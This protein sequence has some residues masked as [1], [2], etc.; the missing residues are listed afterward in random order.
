MTSETIAGTTS[1]RARAATA[2]AMA[3][4]RPGS[5]RGTIAEARPAAPPSGADTRVRMRAAAAGS[6]AGGRTGPGRAWGPAAGRRHTART[7]AVPG[8]ARVGRGG[9]PAC[10]SRTSRRSRPTA[11]TVGGSAGRGPRLG[12]ALP[13][14]ER[15]AGAVG[16]RRALEVVDEARGRGGLLVGELVVEREPRLVGV[17]PADRSERDEVPLAGRRGRCH[18]VAQSKASATGR[19]A[20]RSR[21][22]REVGRTSIAGGASAD[23]RRLSNHGRYQSRYAKV[24]PGSRL[25]CAQAATRR[26]SAPH[27]AARGRRARATRGRSGPRVRS[28]PIAATIPSSRMMGTAIATDPGQELAGAAGDARR[29]RSRP[30]RRAAAG[31]VRRA[32]PASPSRPRRGPPPGRRPGAPGR[33]RPAS[34]GPLW[35]GAQG[36][37]ERVLA[38]GP[39]GGTRRDRP[40]RRL[41]TAVSPVSSASIW[42]IGSAT[43]ISSSPLTFAPVPMSSRGPSP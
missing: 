13:Q 7:R 2:T 29:R 21:D 3:S 8:R 23:A 35:P 41:M 11:S 12:A 33:A 32:A 6:R 19:L 22:R 37:A 20:Y 14:A 4:S 43:R 28:T 1:V 24:A 10:T 39:R 38:R 31:V 18:G 16:A 34:S 9:T 26:S 25:R 17:R 30:G 36:H 5:S 42:R 40:M 15:Q 27:R